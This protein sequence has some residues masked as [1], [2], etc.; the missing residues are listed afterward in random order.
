MTSSAA[1]KAETEQFFAYL[2]SRGWRYA[3]MRRGLFLESMH[4]AHPPRAS[5]D[6][7]R[8]S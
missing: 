8:G 4:W 7:R 2:R 3:L 1:W 5:N 6:N